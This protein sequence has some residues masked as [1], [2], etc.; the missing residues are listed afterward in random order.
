MTFP[1]LTIRGFGWT[2]SSIFNLLSNLLSSFSGW[3]YRDMITV[4][5]SVVGRC[6]S[7]IATAANFSSTD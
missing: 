1:V 2:G 3:V 4:R 7:T 5:P 6:T